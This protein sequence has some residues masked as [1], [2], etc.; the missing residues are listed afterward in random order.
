MVYDKEGRCMAKPQTIKENHIFR[1]LYRSKKCYVYPQLVVYVGR[2]RLNEFRYGITTSKKIGNA[3]QRN[4]CRRVI[5]AALR[6]LDFSSG[7]GYD[8]VIVARSR[9]AFVK[10]T[11]L[12]DVLKESFEKAG[13]IR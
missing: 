7:R 2:N 9:A 1:R 11:E 10:S 5:R 6:E 13:V 12:V 8:V 3:V 4:R